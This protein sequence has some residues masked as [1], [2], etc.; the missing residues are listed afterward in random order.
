[1]F[2]VA[3]DKRIPAVKLQEVAND[4]GSLE[5]SPEDQEID[6]NLEVS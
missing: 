1:M 4:G 6:G 2:G 3:G 5:L